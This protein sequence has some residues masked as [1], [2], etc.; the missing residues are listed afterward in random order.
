MINKEPHIVPYLEEYAECILIQV[1]VVNHAPH[2][3]HVLFVIN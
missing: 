2:G 1:N 3:C